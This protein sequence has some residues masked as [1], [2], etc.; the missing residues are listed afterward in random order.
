VTDP[1]FCEKLIASIGTSDWAMFPHPHRFTIFAEAQLSAQMFK[2]KDQPVLDQVRAYGE[3]GFARQ[4]LYMTTIIARR[5]KGL[6]LA[7]VN[8]MWWR[9]NVRWTIQC[10]IS[11]PVV[12][13]RLGWGCDPVLGIDP[14]NNAYF[15]RDVSHR[16]SGYR[17]VSA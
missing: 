12:L 6:A 14:F 7:A 9:E 11:L 8:E 13:W 17:R 16:M 1:R 4:G 2:Y 15:R 10:Q 3:E 5:N